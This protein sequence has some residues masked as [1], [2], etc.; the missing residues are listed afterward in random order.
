MPGSE[1]DGGGAIS[2]RAGSELIGKTAIATV[3]RVYFRREH[4]LNGEIKGKFNGKYVLINNTYLMGYGI[5]RNTPT[6]LLLPLFAITKISGGPDD[7]FF[8][9]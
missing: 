6:S 8:S 9:A 7:R 2:G 4:A 5:Q 3:K 1:L